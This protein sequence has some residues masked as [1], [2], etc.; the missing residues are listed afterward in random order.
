VKAIT[1][2]KSSVAQLVA[3]S[4]VTRLLILLATGRFLVRSQAEEDVALCFCFLEGCV[5]IFV[6]SRLW[7]L[8][9][10][11]VMQSTGFH[12]PPCACLCWSSFLGW[13]EGLP[14]CG[15]VADA[16]DLDEFRDFGGGFA[17]SV[18]PVLSTHNIHT[19]DYGHQ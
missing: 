17:I 7:F 19:G 18:F 2:S 13:R 4:A 12:S 11:L 9:L 6:C 8:L 15:V 3:R 1:Q 14:R 10:F 16:A 5:P